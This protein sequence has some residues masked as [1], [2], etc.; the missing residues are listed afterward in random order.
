VN[1]LDLDK[2]KSATAW[3][4]LRPFELPIIDLIEVGGDANSADWL[5][6]DS[7]AGLHNK[8]LDLALK[9]AHI[10]I[11]PIAP[12]IFDIEASREFL[13]VLEHERSIRKGKVLLGLVGMRMS[14]NTRAASLLEQFIEGRDLP[15]LAYLRETQVYVNAAFEGKSLFD[16]PL[17]LAQR[18]LEQWE[19]LLDWL[20]KIH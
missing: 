19:Y 12:S 20:D 13:K 16:L 15:V 1:L 14:P 6:I 2:Q 18:E 4:T 7:P 8:N 9:M 3:L 10:I 11:V 5:V 17:S